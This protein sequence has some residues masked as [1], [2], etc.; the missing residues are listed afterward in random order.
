VDAHAR[1]PQ[2]SSPTDFARKKRINIIYNIMYVNKKCIN[3]HIYLI[4]LYDLLSS[5]SFLGRPFPMCAKNIETWRGR[6]QVIVSVSFST[7]SS[8]V[9]PELSNDIHVS[10]YS[11]FLIPHELTVS[12]HTVVRTVVYLIVVS[13]SFSESESSSECC[14]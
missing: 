5:T 10:G 6:H 7:D 1:Q 11:G 12:N 13:F 8:S 14:R 9:H 3:I 4:Y 2:I